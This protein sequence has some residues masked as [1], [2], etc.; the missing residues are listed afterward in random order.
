M[1]R[2][3]FVGQVVG[4][5]FYM[6]SFSRPFLTRFHWFPKKYTTPSLV[7]ALLAITMVGVFLPYL[8]LFSELFYTLRVYQ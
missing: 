7:L 6:A 4:F 8:F 5:V 2:T 3:Y 1:T